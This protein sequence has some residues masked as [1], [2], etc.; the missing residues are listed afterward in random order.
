MAEQNCLV[1]K[2]DGDVI[3]ELAKR[4]YEL[5]CQEVNEERRKRLC[6]ANDLH[7]GL[8]PGVWLNELPWHEMNFDGT[9]TLR[10]EGAFAKEMEQYFRRI[11]FR[12]EHFQADMVV[13][14]YYPLDK[15][16][17]NSGNGVEVQEDVRKTDDG[18]HIVSH[19]YYDVLD[20]EE[21]LAAMRTP[22]LTAHPEIDR[23]NQ[24]LAETLLDGILPVRLCGTQIYYAPWDEIARLRGVE[25]ILFDMVDRPEF[26]HQII[27]KY[28]ENQMSVL[29]QLE[30]LGLLEDQLLD[31]HCTPPYTDDL[32]KSAPGEKVKLKNVWFRSMAQMFSTVSPAMHDE[33]EMEYMRPLMERCGL[34]YYGCCE[35][36]DNKIDLLKTIPNMRK[37]GVSPWA[38]VE[39][40]TEQL[41]K[42][43]VCARKPNPAFVAIEFDRDVVR[44]KTE[45]TIRACIRHGCPYEF[46]LKDI[47]TVSHHPENLIEWNRVVQETIDRYY[48]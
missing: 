35:P 25:P 44:K 37:I 20:T 30:E 19:A 21:K 27:G 4:V 6:A 48:K 12:W 22:V 33:F 26:L 31:L 5:S 28:A 36:L 47:S 14:G 42:D 10:C 13:E 32:L 23:H 45:E 17:E 8:R 9:L 1:G 16:F 3:R 15:S 39:S 46:V 43:Y 18:N 41:G 7:T 34:V 11:L 29:T 24:E 2:R 38:D 40:C